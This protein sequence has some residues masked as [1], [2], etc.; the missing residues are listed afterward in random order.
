MHITRM[1]DTLY[2]MVACARANS[3][4]DYVSC[5]LMVNAVLQKRKSEMFK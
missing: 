1:G 3:L 2:L 5:S 4:E